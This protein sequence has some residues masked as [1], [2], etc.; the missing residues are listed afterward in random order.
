MIGHSSL[1]SI[2]QEVWERLAGLFQV[3]AGTC[4][5]IFLLPELL[6]PRD[7][8]QCKVN[9]DR[10]SSVCLSVRLSV[11][12]VDQDHIGWQSWKVTARTISLTPSLFLAQS[13]STYFQAN[14][15]KL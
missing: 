9:C 15:G 4:W 13:S 7:A 3:A 6:L 14:M 10:M 8:L 5:K 11:M 2:I 1:R 12:L